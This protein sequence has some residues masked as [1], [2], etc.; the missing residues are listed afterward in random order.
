MISLVDIRIA[1][2]LLILA[3]GALIV[4]INGALATKQTTGY[5]IA[6]ISAVAAGLWS[7]QTP[8]VPLAPALGLSAN[9]LTRLFTSYFCFMAAVVLLFSHNYNRYRGIVGEEYPATILFTTFGMVA[10]ASATNLLLL[11]LGLESMTFGF[12]ILAA[13]DREQDVSSEAGLKYLLLG[14][15]SAAFLAFGIGLLYCVSGALGISEIMQ[16]T[17]AGTARNAFNPIALAGWGFLL[18]GIAFK[19][20]LVPAHLW[21][22]DVYET[23]PPPVVAFL[24]G[25]SKAA[26]VLL[27]LVLLVQATDVAILRV[28]MFA[29]ALFSMLVGNLAALRQNRVRRMLAYSSIAQMG[30][31]LVAL[32][33]L[34]GNGLPAAAFYAISYGIMSLA[35]FGAI[36]V[37]EANGCGADLDDYRGRGFTQ[38]VASGVLVIALFALAGIPPTVGFTGKF[39]IFTSAIRAGEN[40]LAILGILTAAVSIYYYLRLVAA[41]YLQRAASAERECMSIYEKVL[42]ALSCI[43]IIVL[44]IFPGQLLDFLKT[45]LL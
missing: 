29:L 4:L 43:L 41:L 27:L 31:V 37:L 1:L 21:T 25:G 22:P 40:A 9:G 36:G 35:A 13:I 3:I 30:Y 8:P 2:P 6:I 23:A 44:G 15:L 19:L 45:Q 20:S 32:V 7:M 16:T 28:P 33:S 39:L 17:L 11:F 18:V 10:L 38:P 12:Y 42:L 26:A 5:I 34:Q 14:A 24:S